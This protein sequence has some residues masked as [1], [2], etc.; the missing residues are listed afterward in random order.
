MAVGD[1]SSTPSENV[2]IS[3]IPLPGDQMITLPRRLRAT[4]QQ[5][6]ADLKV[7]N[8]GITAGSGDMTK[9]VYDPKHGRGR[10][11]R[12]GQ[13]GRGDQPHPDSS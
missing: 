4:L 8:D 13:H 1:Y 5:L 2:D 12:H 10:C 7:L 3:G 9:A 11:V 6:M